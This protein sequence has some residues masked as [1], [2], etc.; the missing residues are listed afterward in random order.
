MTSMTIFR[1]VRMFRGDCFGGMSYVPAD[2]TGVP[3]FRSLTPISAMHLQPRQ[4]TRQ[5]L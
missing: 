1:V 3:P 2:V 4:I 5:R